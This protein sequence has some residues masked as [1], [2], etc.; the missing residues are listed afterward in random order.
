MLIYNDVQKIQKYIYKYGD[1]N[2][3]QKI[4]DVQIC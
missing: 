4:I 1:Y 3:V 2:D